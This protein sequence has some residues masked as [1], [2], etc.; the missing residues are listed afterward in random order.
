MREVVTPSRRLLVMNGVT[1]SIKRGHLLAMDM[2]YGN[3]VDTDLRTNRKTIVI[4]GLRGA[5]GLAQGHD[6]TF[7]V[8]S[9]DNGFLYGI[10][11]DGEIITPLLQ[12]IG[13]GSTADLYLDEKG[14]RV[15]VPDTL[16]G[17]IITVALP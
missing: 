12:G 11:K 4:T 7:Y 14:K 17:T 3:L 2:F 6:G 10:S 1:E 13:F 9:F 5:D 8:S 16:H 15:L